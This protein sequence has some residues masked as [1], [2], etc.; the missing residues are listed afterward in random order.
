MKLNLEKE[1]EIY[2]NNKLKLSEFNP[3]ILI[4]FIFIN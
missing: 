3:N 4:I 1:T 2:N